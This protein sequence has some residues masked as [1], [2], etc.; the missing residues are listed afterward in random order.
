MKALENFI[1][2]LLFKMLPFPAYLRIVSRMY[3]IVS[4]SGLV[5]G[6]AFYKYHYFMQK[7]IRKGDVVIDMGANLGYFTV[8]FSRL[9]GENGRVFA[10]EPI[11][12]VRRVLEKNIGKRQNVEVVPYALGDEN[13]SIRM[14][15][16]T[17]SKTGKIATGSH[18][19]LDSDEQATD[20]FSAEMRKGSELFGDLKKIDFIKC[21][22]EGHETVILTEME[23]I[24]DDRKPAILV[25][26]RKEKRAFLTEF[27]GKMGYAAFVLEGDRLY[28][29]EQIEEKSIDDV[30]FL[31]GHRIA[32]FR[33]M[34]AEAGGS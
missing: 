12:V 14:G 27:L 17:R 22:V 33:E 2:R 34:I 31:P 28:P 6:V 16:D 26:T 18:Y 29:S 21:D 5:R 9:T 24:L 19:V 4:G 8:P 20:E 15:N 11:E 1:K 23:K 3:F 13:K 32:E 10:V 25:E 30:L 7:V